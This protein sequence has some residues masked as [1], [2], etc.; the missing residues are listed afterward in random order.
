MLSAGTDIPWQVRSP[1]VSLDYEANGA[2]EGD[3]VERYHLAQRGSGT[4]RG[5]TER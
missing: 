2:E 3:I 1:S 4:R 5:E